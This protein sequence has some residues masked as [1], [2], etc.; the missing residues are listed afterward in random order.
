[1]MKTVFTP[2]ELKQAP[3][4][5]PEPIKEAPKLGR[6]PK[7]PEA[8][9]GVADIN[10]IIEAQRTFNPNLPPAKGPSQAMAQQGAAPAMDMTGAWGKP[11]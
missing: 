4:K 6:P 8:P 9:R 5:K 3:E 7:K 11:Q 2:P 10:L 1:M